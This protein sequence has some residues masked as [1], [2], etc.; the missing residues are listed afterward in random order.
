MMWGIY[1]IEHPF[2]EKYKIN[3]KHW[4]WYE[5]LH[6]WSVLLKKSM[7]LIT[8]NS[9]VTVPL[10]LLINVSMSNW[11]LEMATSIEELPTPKTLI[12]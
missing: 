12:L 10:L 11:E 9:F 7:L 1:H 8:F 6:E 4:P 3:S 2:F 5:N